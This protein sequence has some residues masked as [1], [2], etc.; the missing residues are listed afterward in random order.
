M[1]VCICTCVR[2]GKAVC[3]CIVYFEGQGN[4][5]HKLSIWSKCTQRH[6]K[7]HPLPLLQVKVM[8]HHKTF[9]L[10]LMVSLLLA[11][12]IIVL[13]GPEVPW[14]LLSLN[15]TNGKDSRVRLR[16]NFL[17]ITCCTIKRKEIK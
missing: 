13:T 16:T 5:R 1:F 12:K 4:I 14:T 11:P 17:S 15:R 2:E 8:N 10:W 6:R 7:Q 3:V 9:L